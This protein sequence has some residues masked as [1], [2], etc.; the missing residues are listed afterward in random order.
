MS[1]HKDDLLSIAR[2]IRM[3]LTNCQQKLSELMR[4]IAALELPEPTATICP[5]C[6][7]KLAGPNSL[8]E[9]LYVS[10]A[11]PLPPAWAKADALAAP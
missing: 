10:H 3:D 8:A 7:L 6:T 11:G 4:E 5:H 9:H 1:A 2:S